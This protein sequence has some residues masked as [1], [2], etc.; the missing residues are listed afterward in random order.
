MVNKVV[1]KIEKDHLFIKYIIFSITMFIS[2]INF[3]I[4]I[5]P[6]K[7][8]AGGVNGLAILFED[9]VNI[10]PSLFIFLF[11]G[12][13]LLLSL[14]I[15]GFTKASSIFLFTITYPFFVRITSFV[16]QYFSIDKGDLL[17]CSIF[18][19]LTTGMV[20]GVCYKIGLGAGP[21]P[22]ISQMINKYT[23]LPLGKITFLINT[24][25]VTISAYRYGVEKVIYALIIIYINSVVIDKILLSISQNKVL[26]VVSFKHKQIESYLTKSTKIKYQIFTM[27]DI[28]NNYKNQLIIID[29]KTTQYKNLK[30]KLKQIDQKILIITMNTR[31]ENKLYD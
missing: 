18:I 25:I 5:K 6:S 11:S 3:N 14:F 23:K 1:K 16:N 19:G 17:L 20:N 29:V 24:G 22:L 4:L 13:V 8:V 21:I 31:L 7:I 12:G 26:Y 28:N 30:E 10:P 9:F 2:A 27:N 15:L